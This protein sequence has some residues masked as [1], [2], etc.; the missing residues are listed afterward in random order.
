MNFSATQP[1]DVK[2][3]FIGVGYAA[4]AFTLL[5]HLVHCCYYYTINIIGGGYVIDGVI[6][7][8]NQQNIE[9]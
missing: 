4:R 1:A 2:L 8:V 6:L 7:S 9:N 3:Q 5:Q